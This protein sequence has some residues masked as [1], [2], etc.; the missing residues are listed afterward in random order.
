MSQTELK[1]DKF[2]VKTNDM[3]F[4]WV[5]YIILLL[6]FGLFGTW[7]YVAPI[8]SAAIAPGHISVTFNNKTIQHLEGGIIKRLHV[9]EGIRVVSGD[10]LIELD[11]T[12]L[13]AQKE[14]L[15]SEYAG[16]KS[17][18]RNQSELEISYFEEVEELTVL[19]AEGFADKGE[20][21][22]RQRQL[23]TVQVATAEV[24]GKMASIKEG[25]SAIEDRLQKTLI[26]APVTGNVIGLNVHTIGG[27]ISPGSEI[28][29]IVPDGQALMISAQI[30]PMDIDRVTVGL[31]AEIRLSAFNQSTTPKLLGK[32]VNLS[33]DRLINKNTGQPYYEAELALHPESLR[34][35]AALKLLPGMPAEV[36]ILT[37]ERTLIEY[38][39]KPITDAFAR[40]LLED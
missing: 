16:L 6:T 12:Q 27:V 26:R 39:G 7:S 32:V 28:L 29:D 25:L 5:G 23:R 18:Q 31:S 40:S 21:R 34:D 15:N 20:I 17:Q 19:L 1:H 33:A 38:L 3:S 8:D 4:R 30:A 22:Q 10:I 13:K 11:D 9:Q 2:E 37:G 36:L 35:L 14:Q 24:N